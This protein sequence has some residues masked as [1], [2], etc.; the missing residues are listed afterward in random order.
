MRWFA[1]SSSSLALAVLAG[2]APESSGPT[3]TEGPAALAAKSGGS[4]ALYN[5][6]VEGDFIMPVGTDA[7][8][9]VTRSSSDPFAGSDIVIKNVRFEIGPVPSGDPT[10]CRAQF[11]NV[12]LVAD[13]NGNEGVWTGAVTIS[14][15]YLNLK[16]SRVVNGVTEYVQSS[17][18]SQGKYSETSS[19]GNV[20]S[21]TFRNTLQF[22][23]GN[24]GT[25]HYDG[26]YRC[27]T[28]KVVLTP[29]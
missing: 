29:A 17:A 9:Q 7:A 8:P 25:T 28:F 19:E 10:T 4:R 3:S 15:S 23:G 21:L 14:D 20:W 1:V 26:Q 6:A 24:G 27:V 18:N 5:V 11:P 12:T 2:C 13:W 16:G 22:F